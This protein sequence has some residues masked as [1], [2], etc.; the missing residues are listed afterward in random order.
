MTSIA[1]WLSATQQRLADAGIS[2]AR[3]DAELLLTHTL[4]RPHT[5]LHAH[6]DEQITP[7]LA[8]IADARRTLR[9]QRVPLA[10][11]IGHREF[12]GCQFEVTPATLIPRPETETLVELFLEL[13]PS[14]SSLTVVDIGTGTGC[15]GI[16]LA[17]E[18]PACQ[19]TLCDTS[20]E[21]LAVARRNA[22]AHHANVAFLQSD[23]LQ[24]YSDMADCIV[25]N[26]PYV[27]P[28]WECSPETAHE[29]APALFA[30]HDGLYLIYRLIDESTGHL[31]PRGLLFL[32]S[33]PRQHAAIR[34]YATKHGLRHHT[35]RGFI[36]VFRRD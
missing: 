9:E 18:R 34:I 28:S 2:S 19:T 4:S 16:T 1:H 21:A 32:E 35:T 31:Q 13:T 26:L 12:Y 5:Y 10:Y 27:D 11:I 30:S 20:L 36:Q 3:L 14:D 8:A 24:S 17:L 22:A 6:P 23:L 7:Q 29:P 15:I 33:D 25:A